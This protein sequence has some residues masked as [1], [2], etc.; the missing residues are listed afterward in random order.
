MVWWSGIPIWPPKNS[1]IISVIRLQILDNK[2]WTCNLRADTKPDFE[3][4][5]RE[6][7]RNNQGHDNSRACQSRSIKSKKRAQIRINGNL[8]LFPS[9]FCCA[10]LQN[11]AIEETNSRLY[12][13]KWVEQK[14]WLWIFNKCDTNYQIRHLAFWR[15]KRKV[16][17]GFCYVNWQ[18]LWSFHRHEISIF[19]LPCLE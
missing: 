12:D 5:W 7:W 1:Y 8:E 10:F 11:I 15:R 18:T 4:I 3:Y 9:N 14:I 6:N 13:L 17:W 16:F 19:T 2:S